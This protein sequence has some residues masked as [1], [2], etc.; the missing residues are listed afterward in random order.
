MEV[1]VE[2]KPS[3][4]MTAQERKWQAED[5]LRALK[6]VNEIKGDK[7]RYRR[8][9]RLAEEQMKALKGLKET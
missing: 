1:A 9:L 2:D 7:P 8:A 3:S 4:K 6:R 5:D